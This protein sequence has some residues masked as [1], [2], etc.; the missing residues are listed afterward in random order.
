MFIAALLTLLAPLK[1]V[2]IPRMEL[3]A[4][5]LSTRLDRMIREEL[6]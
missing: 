3:S 5:V 6:E 4:I 1:P 2:N